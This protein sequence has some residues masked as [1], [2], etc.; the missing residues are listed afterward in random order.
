M[1]DNN[2]NYQQVNLVSCTEEDG[3][4]YNVVLSVDLRINGQ[5]DPDL[6][7]DIQNFYSTTDFGIPDIQTRSYVPEYL[8]TVD[9]IDP[10]S[11]EI[12][13]DDID[14]GEEVV[15]DGTGD[16]YDDDFDLFTF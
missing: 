2:V 12:T 7:E 9:L 10:S 1:K 4:K 3:N 15:C 5:V 11:I 6:D 8:G 16:V 14:Y 13:V